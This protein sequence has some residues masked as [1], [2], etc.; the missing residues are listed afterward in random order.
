ME[1]IGRNLIVDEIKDRRNL[2]EREV[3]I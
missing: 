1:R 3:K 2:K